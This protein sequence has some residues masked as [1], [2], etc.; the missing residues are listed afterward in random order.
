MKTI[1]LYENLLHNINE[2]FETTVTGKWDCGNVILNVTSKWDCRTLILLT[3][4]CHQLAFLSVCL[5]YK[6]M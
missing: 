1:R 3:I 6:P 2:P 5:F 4:M